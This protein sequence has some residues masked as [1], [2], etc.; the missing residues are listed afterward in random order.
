VYFHGSYVDRAAVHAWR[1]GDKDAQ[2]I[3]SFEGPLQGLG[4]GWF[5]HSENGRYARVRFDAADE[6]A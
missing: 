3:A 6:A 4:D 1:R 2:R 5:L